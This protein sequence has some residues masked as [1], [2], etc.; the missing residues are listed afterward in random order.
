MPEL[1]LENCTEETTELCAKSQA[2]KVHN[3]SIPTNIKDKI[4]TL[5]KID[6]RDLA[7]GMYVQELDRPWIETP[8]M[9][10]GFKIQNQDEI[11]GLHTLCEFVYI[12]IERSINVPVT[13]RT[14]LPRREPRTE[15]LKRISC[16]PARKN[17]YADKTTVENELQTA[18]TIYAESRQAIK[19][20]FNS[21]QQGEQIS[22]Q[23]IH[24]AADGV[25][26]SV[27]RN[28]DAFMLMR[29]LK[30]K[31]TYS[32]AHAIDSCA[33]AA[34]FCRHLGIPETELR[35]I[36]TGALMLDIGT[37]KLPSKLLEQK[38]PLTPSSIK[39]I[40]HHVKFGYNILRKTQ[41]ISRVAV[42]MVATHHERYSG[43]GYPQG[44]KGNE[45]PVSG[46]IA[47]IVDCFDAMTSERP[48]KHAIS[49]HEALRELY[50]WRDI[51][52]HAELV[53]QFIQC[54]G[55]FPTGTLV[56]LNSGQVGIVL[57]QNRR[58]R[59]YPKL[60][61]IL[62]ADKEHYE[63]PHTLDLWDHARKYKGKVLEIKRSVSAED[64]NIDP[65]DFYL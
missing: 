27:L 55:L 13:S 64:Y 29:K 46:R 16:I 59:L 6:T 23:A 5:K 52:F 60:L 17:P 20:M 11:D 33:L 53:E 41:G 44:M 43:K 63:K 12:D 40:Q 19:S 31:E 22:I 42:E 10:Q 38:D 32:Y 36:A 56:E 1:I 62:N 34:T 61:L 37:I 7:I 25:V 47:A 30:E 15:Q 54:L 24:K 50:K 35:D 18:K 58:R 39:L 51:D 4:F 45:I 57:S 21:L 48:Y 49:P 2:R 65:G 28:P 3:M 9:F 14:P 26:E 8:F